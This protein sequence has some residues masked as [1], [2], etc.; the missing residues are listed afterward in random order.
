MNY[1][2]EPLTQPGYL[3]TFHCDLEMTRHALQHSAVCR[4]HVT[5]ANRTHDAIA[6]GTGV[7][8]P[9]RASECRFG[10][11]ALRRTDAAGERACTLSAGHRCRHPDTWREAT[12][13]S[14]RT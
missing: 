7:R 6:W 8:P 13:F 2:L 3:K 10:D 14:N 12:C 11:G 4:V 5:G 1:V 9:H